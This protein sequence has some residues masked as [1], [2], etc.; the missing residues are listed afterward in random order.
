MSNEDLEDFNE[1]VDCLTL[2]HFDFIMKRP[3]WSDCHRSIGGLRSELVTRAKRTKLFDRIRAALQTKPITVD[4]EGLKKV[5][6]KERF[7][8]EYGGDVTTHDTIRAY[9][10]AIDDVIKEMKK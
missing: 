10:Q 1:L 2:S 3:T 4:I 6:C 9:N 8:K 7:Y 5:F